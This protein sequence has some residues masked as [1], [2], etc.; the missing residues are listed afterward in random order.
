MVQ[1]NVFAVFLV[2]RILSVFVVKTW[3]VPDEYWQS[4]EVAHKLTFGYGYLTWEWTKGIRSYIYPLF[5][6]AVYQILALFG[7][8]QVEYLILAPRILQAMLSAISDYCF[9]R[10]TNNSKWSIFLI[11]TS[12]FW[13][14][15]ATRTLINTVETCLT[16][17]ALSL[18][19]RYYDR[20]SN[21]F[22]WIVALVCFIRPTAAILWLPLCIFHMRKSI[23]SVAELLIKRYLLIGLIVGAITILLDSYAHGEWIMTPVEFFK[24]NVLEG[25]ASFYGTQPS[26]W[27][28]S[29]GL[30]TILGPFAMPFLFAIIQTV[31]HR[32]IFVDRFN[33][34][35]AI[36]FTLIVYSCLGHKEFRFIL[37]LLP[38]CLH[39]TADS[40]AIWSQ[41]A[42]RLTIWMVAILLFTMNAVPAMYFSLTHQRGTIDVMHS[43]ERISREYRDPAGNQAKI[44][45]LMPC[46]STPWYSHVHQNVSMRFLTCEP[47]VDGAQFYTDEAEQFFANPSKWLRFNLPVYPKSVMPT[48]AVLFDNLESQISDFLKEYKL[49]ETINHT[50]YAID[51]IGNNV[52]LYEHVFDDAKQQ[53]TERNQFNAADDTISN[54]PSHNEL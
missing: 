44:I 11:A 42:S 15:V 18:Y 53:T 40:L 29:V 37:P 2:L 5:I 3:Y 7:I 9:Y 14:Y 23:H 52:L 43:I 33:L 36:A 51:R 16:T 49:I 41:K 54:V 25:V 13:F 46:H 10:W 50:E 6:A 12:W 17:I 26:Y 34:L 45:F 47:N 24:F 21:K 19:P 48:H 20:D 35:V 1:F 4:L 8:D 27:Y 30:P 31:Q 38:I 28:F 39:I 22:L 32:Q